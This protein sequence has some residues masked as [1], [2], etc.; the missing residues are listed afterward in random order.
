MSVVKYVPKSEQRFREGSGI[1][2]L[3]TDGV[4]I[5]CQGVSK[6]KLNRFR[7]E[8]NDPE[9][10]SDDAWPEAQ[11]DKGA[12]PGTYLCKFHGGK[13]LGMVKNPITQFMPLDLAEKML[14]LA[15]N[16]DYI[17]RQSEIL[18]L[19]A[20]N[21]QLYERL[22]TRAV[23]P[24]LQSEIR[25]ALKYLSNNQINEASSTLRDIL[26]TTYSE[27]ELHSELR[28]NIKIIDKMTSTQVNTAKELRTMATSDQVMNMIGG[29][30]DA[31]TKSVRKHVKE[32][33]VAENI[34][35]EIS[36]AIRLLATTGDVGVIDA[37]SDGSSD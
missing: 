18:Q 12:V 4:T 29:I 20:R 1:R 9:L 25:E 5:R 6:V 26:D 37:I 23:H 28:E 16:P 19:L 21:A 34:L 30:Y 11:C 14:A 3:K 36:G 33:P 13:S 17:N 15:E 8:H 35:L 31:L 2:Y 10:T 7:E 22:G 24:E 27:R 32:I